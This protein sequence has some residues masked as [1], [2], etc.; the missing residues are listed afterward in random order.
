[1]PGLLVRTW[2]RLR[3][4]AVELSREP[5]SAAG[6]DLENFIAAGSV[7]AALSAQEKALNYQVTDEGL[8]AVAGIADPETKEDPLVYSTKVDQE[9]RRL[10]GFGDPLPQPVVAPVMAIHHDSHGT[11]AILR[12]LDSMIPRA[13]LPASA[14]A[15]EEPDPVA[16]LNAWV[17]QKSELTAYL[18]M[19]KNLLVK[20]GEEAL[21]KHPLSDPYAQVYRDLVLATAWQESCWRQFI[22]KGDAITP[23]VSSANSVGLMQVNPRVWRGMYDVEGLYGDIR[24]NGRAGC[25]ILLHYLRDYAIAK[26]EDKLDGGIDNLPRATY[27]IY[28]GGPGHRARYRSSTTSSSLKKIDAALW[29]KYA[30]VRAGNEMEVANCYQ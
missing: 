13:W 6:S 2:K 15:A 14:W 27:A 5:A 8:R 3:P 9:L 12:L 16:K 26:G 28:N 21:A 19:V 20:L 17:P 18:E 4:V 1:V 7:L 11:Q 25:E 23:L 30:A 24:Y 29:Q 22:R 10:F